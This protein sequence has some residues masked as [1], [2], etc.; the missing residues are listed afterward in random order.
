M[1]RKLMLAKTRTLAASLVLAGAAI[2][3]SAASA[4][5][6]WGEPGCYQAVE[7]EC[8][9]EWQNWGYRNLQDCQRLE[10]C[11][12]CLYGYLCGYSD[13][14]APGKPRED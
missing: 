14:W 1:S 4:Q 13:Y 10:P 5:Y 11:Y 8:T 12:Y 7:S 9:T 3:S 2:F 6:T